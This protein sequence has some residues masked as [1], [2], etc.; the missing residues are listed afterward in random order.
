VDKRLDILASVIQRK[1][2]IFE[3]TE[4]EHA[5]A[6]PFSSAK[7]P[8]N[9]AGFVAENILEKQLHLFYWDQVAD[10]TEDDIILDVRTAK[11]FAEGSIEG[12]INIPVDELRERINELPTDK[13]ILLFCQVGLRGYLAYRILKQKGFQQVF[14]LSGGYMLY[15]SCSEERSSLERAS[16]SNLL[17]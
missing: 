1:S 10:A 2:T 6:P 15:K 3:L 13:R 12:A 14:S 17:L 9:I 16:T 5:Y 8:I 7:D 11:E 4:F